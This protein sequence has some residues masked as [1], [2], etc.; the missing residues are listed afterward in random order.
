[1]SRVR[2]HPVDEKTWWDGWWIPSKHEPTLKAPISG[3]RSISLEGNPLVETVSDSTV[4]FISHPTGA[5][6]QVVSAEPLGEPRITLHQNHYAA[7]LSQGALLGSVQYGAR[8]DL[9]ASVSAFVDGPWS[10]GSRPTGLALRVSPHGCSTPR[11]PGIIVRADGRVAIGGGPAALSGP[12][13]SLGVYRR[14]IFELPSVDRYEDLLDGRLAGTTAQSEPDRF[15]NGAIVYARDL[16]RV[17]IS[18]GGVWAAIATTPIVS[19]VT[20]PPLYAETTDTPS[21]VGENIPKRSK[22]FGPRSSH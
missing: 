12:L 17:L 7:A 11:H 16:D 1:M 19:T 13:V 8:D 14:G 2:H 10:S 6:V 15:V 9:T 5:A 4:R 22:T 20:T 18:Q 3:S 21:S